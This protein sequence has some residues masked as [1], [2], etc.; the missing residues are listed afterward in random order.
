[1]YAGS[2]SDRA[3]SGRIDR[4]SGA[5]SVAFFQ[6]RGLLGRGAVA[7]S[8]VAMPAAVMPLALVRG[9]PPPVFNDQSVVLW[10]QLQPPDAGRTATAGSKTYHGSM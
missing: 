9:G 5:N 4:A 10:V 1:M 2:E 8:R 7:F 3:L 6:C